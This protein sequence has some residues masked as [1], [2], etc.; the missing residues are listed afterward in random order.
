MP[1]EDVRSKNIVEELLD[2][3][4]Y[5]SLP[6]LSFNSMLR[7]T[8]VK[9]DLCPPDQEDMFN[10]FNDNR[11][12]GFTTCPKRYFKANHKYL[13]NYDPT[14]PSAFIMPFDSNGMYS[15]VQE[16]ELPKEDYQWMTDEELRNWEEFLETDG[17]RCFLVCD[18]DYPLELHNEHNS[19][20]YL[21][22]H[23]NGRLDAHLRNRRNF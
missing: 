8:G 11:R 3:A 17:E 2:P 21:P 5:I 7:L 9:L 15:Y 20:P 16:D 22:D 13:K 14:K 23:L 10:L 18:I 1:M 12:G 19:F 4:N 6:Q